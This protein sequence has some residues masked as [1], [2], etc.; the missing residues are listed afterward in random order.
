[1]PTRNRR[2]FI[3]LALRCFEAQDYNQKE[4]IIVDDGDD[5]V[6]DLIHGCAQVQ[7]RRLGERHSIG[8]KRNA[9]C[10]LAQ[11]QV[12]MLWD[13]DDWYGAKTLLFKWPLTMRR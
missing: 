11:G 2:A 12:V 3:H 13:D 4:L 8:D 9:A 1:M 5:P 6:G 10:E 7:Y